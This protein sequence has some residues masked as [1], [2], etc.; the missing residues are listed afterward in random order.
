[1]TFVIQAIGVVSFSIVFMF[2]D[3]NLFSNNLYKARISKEKEDNIQNDH[4]EENKDILLVKN[5]KDKDN[6]KRDDSVHKHD[7]D[8]KKQAENSDDHHNDN[9]YDDK[10]NPDQPENPHHQQQDEKD[11]DLNTLYEEKYNAQKTNFLKDFLALLK[12]PIFMFSSL[13]I[14][15]ILFVSNA[16][17]FWTTNYLTVVMGFNETLVTTYFI[18]AVVTA[19]VGGIIA[20]GAIVQKIFDGYDKK[21][22]ILYICF[23]LTLSSFFIPPIYFLDDLI[24]IILMLW[25]LLFFGASAIPNLQGISISCLPAK[26]RASGN[27]ICNLFIF[28]IGF[29][30]S[31][32]FYGALF[33]A[34]GDK[35]KKLP[36]VL[37][38][39]FGFVA[40]VFSVLCGIFR[41]RHFNKKEKIHEIKE[42]ERLERL[43]KLLEEEE[44]AE[45]T[46]KT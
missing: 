14:T 5:D 23:A 22:S 34:F 18:A 16:M 27:S 7:H 4:H 39:S 28:G 35:D 46:Q 42:I 2:F 26:L 43:N 1:M 10:Q 9:H 41:Y 19:P 36:Y 11:F 3:N 37:T 45:K 44:K 13:S 17:T 30:V 32:L 33:D 40:L 38:L 29:T 8:H 20:G 15:S 25:G 21:H 24:W 6:K 12:Q 31:P